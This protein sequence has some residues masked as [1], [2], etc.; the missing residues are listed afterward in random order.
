MSLYTGKDIHI[1]DWIELPIDD[2]VF[3]RVEELEQIE[4]QPTFYQY[5]MFDWAPGITI[6]DDMKVNEYKGSDKENPEDELIE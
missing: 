4:E 3:K 6:L 1:N 5:P 2:E